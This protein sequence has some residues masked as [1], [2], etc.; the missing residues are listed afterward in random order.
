MGKGDKPMTNPR[1]RGRPAKGDDKAQRI[2][3]TL[4]PQALTLIDAQPGQRSTLIEAL[5]T[6]AFG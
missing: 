6:K 1:P 3:I 4:S 5:I 2:N